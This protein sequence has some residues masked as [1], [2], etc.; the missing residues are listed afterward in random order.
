LAENGKPT[1]CPSTDGQ[2]EKE[3]VIHKQNGI[4]FIPKKCKTV[5][6]E[7]VVELASAMLSEVS[8]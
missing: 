4:V 7:N 5:I 1:K 6:C 8:Q 2:M 3:N